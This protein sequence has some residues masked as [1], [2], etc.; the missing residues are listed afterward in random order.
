MKIIIEI[1]KDEELEKIKRALKGENI[2]IVNTHKDKKK[3]LEAIFQN[4]NIRLP[5]N[6][7]FN[8]EKIHAR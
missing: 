8:R 3:I 7:K 6:Y 1:E 4:Y 5:K 2:T